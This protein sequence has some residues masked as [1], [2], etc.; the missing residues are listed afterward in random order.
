M[1]NENKPPISFV[2]FSPNG[3]YIITATLDNTLHLL[4]FTKGKCLRTYIGHKNEKCRLFSDFS[5]TDGKASDK[6]CY[7]SI[8]Y[9]LY[10]FCFCF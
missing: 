8:K 10:L 9:I 5:V 2:K 4:N 3:R 6:N 1:V 7:S